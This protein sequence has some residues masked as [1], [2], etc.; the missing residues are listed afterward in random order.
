MGFDISGMTGGTGAAGVGV[1]AGVVVDGAPLDE[2][3][4]SRAMAVM[5]LMPP[6]FMLS[7][8]VEGTM[9]VAEPPVFITS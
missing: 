5:P 2:M 8:A 7:T 4:A 9:T 6:K 1:G 3:T